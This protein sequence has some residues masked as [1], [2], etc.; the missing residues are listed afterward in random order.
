MPSYTIPQYLLDRANIHDTITKVPLYYDT[1]NLPGLLS[2]VYA[3][4]IEIDYTS[5]L[6]GTPYTVT[7]TAWVDEVGS[8]L[9]K[10]ASTQHVTS[11]IITSLPQPTANATRPERVTVQAQAAGNMVSKTPTEG[12]AAQLMQNGGLL[13]AELVRDAVLESQGH[14]PWRITKYKVIKKWERGDKTVL[15]FAKET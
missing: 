10:F 7:R 5:I 8:L 4:S 3:P 14:N 13:E 11:G 2:E 9:G 12:A 1:H 15:D 6:G